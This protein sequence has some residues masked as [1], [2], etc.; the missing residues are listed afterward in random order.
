[1]NNLRKN[2]INLLIQGYK[3]NINYF[4]YNEKEDSI[5]KICADCEEYINNLCK[6][7]ERKYRSNIN[8]FV[9]LLKSKNNYDMKINYLQGSMNSDEFINNIYNNKK[10]QLSKKNINKNF[11]SNNFD[12]IKKR[13]ANSQKKEL[14]IIKEENKK[15]QK[16]NYFINSQNK[17]KT[18]KNIYE[19]KVQI[20]K[21][22]IN[23]FNS[24]KK[25]TNDNNDELNYNNIIMTSDIN[26]TQS[27]TNNIKI[28]N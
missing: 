20:Q 25:K 9:F 10:R 21:T 5:N 23:P 8:N 19:N 1:M 24:I 15:K 6:N 28:Y 3:F 12:I 2:A 18:N 4:S 17:D 22:I 13:K 16:D 7:E 26:D 14:N 27:N 11:S